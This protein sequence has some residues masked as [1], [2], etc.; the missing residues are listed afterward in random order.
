LKRLPAAEGKHIPAIALTAYAVLK[1][2]RKPSPRDFA[3]TWR[4]R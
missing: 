2:A 1:I 4:N 3:R